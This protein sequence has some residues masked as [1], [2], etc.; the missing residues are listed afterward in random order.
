M[1]SAALDERVVQVQ[2]AIII[3]TRNQVPI[4]RLSQMKPYIPTQ[5]IARRGRT[6]KNPNRHSTKAH[7]QNRQHRQPLLCRPRRRHI[8]A[9]LLRLIQFMLIHLVK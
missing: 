5:S 1:D 7:L 8:L 9:R 3:Q 6:K 4:K 2:T